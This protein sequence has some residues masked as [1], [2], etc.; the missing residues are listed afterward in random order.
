MGDSG[1]GRAT[2]EEEGQIETDGRNIRIAKN[3]SAKPKE[4]AEYMIL[5]GQEFS[6]S[7]SF[8][9]PARPKEYV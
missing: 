7:N 1:V 4:L 8:V 3:T 2:F 6:L 9:N 5:L